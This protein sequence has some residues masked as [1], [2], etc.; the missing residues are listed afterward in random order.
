M[1]RKAAVV[2][3]L[4][5]LTVGATGLL[6]PASG[7]SVTTNTYSATS[8]S[9]DIRASCKELSVDS[10]ATLSAKCNKEDDSGVVS[11]VSTTIDMLTYANCQATGRGYRVKWGAASANVTLVDPLLLLTST[12]SSYVFGGYCVDANNV[13]T[14][15]SGEDIGDTTD[16]L[17]NDAGSLA[18]R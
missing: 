17:K 16:G 18:K 2:A 13:K 4:A 15:P 7:T 3:V 1:N 11:A 9:E 10:Q 14:G 12:G 5:A 6:A 8:T